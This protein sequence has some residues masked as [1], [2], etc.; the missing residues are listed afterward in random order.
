MVSMDFKSWTDGKN[1]FILCIYSN[2]RFKTDTDGKNGY[3][4]CTEW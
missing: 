4:P 1:E 2:N 3:K